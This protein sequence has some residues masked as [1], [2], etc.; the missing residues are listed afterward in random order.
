MRS[1]GWVDAATVDEYLGRVGTLAPRLAGEAMVLE[2]LPAHV[3]RV[4]DLGCGDGR[5]VTL[6][7]DARSSVR[8]VVALDRSP[9]MLARARDRFAPDERVRVLDWDLADALPDIGMF[10]AV[11]SG[12]AIHH[13]DDMRKRALFREVRA[14]L[15]AGGV[16]ANLEV[17]ASA[18]PELHAAF[19]AAV[20]REEDDPEDRLV[21]VETQLGWMRDAGLDQVDCLWRW[22]GFA[23]LFGQAPVGPR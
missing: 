6:V 16:F 11:V 12:F 4:A 14:R 13:L 19:R 18:T 5:L 21:D 17:V 7:L 3:E 15:V 23:L 22:R 2:V 20:G 8:E 10:D 9:P 1:R